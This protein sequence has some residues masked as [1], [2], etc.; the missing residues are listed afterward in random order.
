[1]SAREVPDGGSSTPRLPAGGSST[2]GLPAGGSSTPRLPAGGGVAVAVLALLVGASLLAAA[3]ESESGSGSSLPPSLAVLSPY[4]GRSPRAPAGDE[5]RVLVAL[6]RPALGER[7]DVR[8]LSPG[9]QSAYV[10]SLA[11]EEES[12]RSA[13]EA[14]G[15]ALREV[16]S[17]GRTWNGFAATVDTS[18]LAALSS[19]GVRTQPV[20]RFFPAT[21]E[22]VPVRAALPRPGREPP[23]GQAPVALLDTGVDPGVPALRGRVAAG[24]DALDRDG[25]A[26]PGSDPRAPSRRETT[27]TALAGLLAAAG[28]RVLP[29]RVAG[30]GTESPD[31]LGRTDTLLAGLESAVDPDGDG[32]V[33]DA[34]RVALVGVNAP[35]AGFGDAPEADAVRSAARLGT[36]VVAAAGNEGRATGPYGVI[37]SPGGAP[38]A[39]TAGAAAGQGRPARVE[40]D[41]GEEA[42]TG[43]AVLAGS[44]AGRAPLAGPVTGT[45]P[46]RLLRASLQ[47]RAVVVRAN[48]NPAA[49]AAAAAAAGAR[50]VILAEPRPRRPLPLMAAGRVPAPVV[51]VTGEAAR[52]VLAA[53]PR[54][55]VAFGRVT[56]DQPPA[57][58]TPTGGTTPGGTT[59][60]GTTPGGT[61]PGGTTPGGTTPGGTTPGGAASGGAVSGGAVAGGTTTPARP[62]VFSSEGPALDG[63]PKP[64]VLADG[65]ALAPLPG[66]GAGIVAGTA[67]AAARVAAR[68]SRLARERPESTA[69]ALRADLTGTPAAGTATSAP[70]VPLGPLRLV[71]RGGEVTG[72]RFTLGAFDRGDPLEQGARLEPAG[73]LELVLVRRDGT[74]ARRLTPPGGARDLIPAEYAYTLPNQALD[75]LGPGTH[76]FR[77][78]ARPPRR[79][80]AATKRS[81]SFTR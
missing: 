61:T 34:V 21:S 74:V 70:R 73:R 50:T 55:P 16:V 47:G 64:D 42:I 67:V 20:R 54:T 60:G 58:G 53:T 57:A 56:A 23:D 69:A 13:L 25:F 26:G 59:P 49:Q 27:G 41:V 28:E 71:R 36:L 30:Y 52:A 6:A 43:A 11:R 62:A 78:T 44:P 10:R 8:D 32:A 38:A 46:Q 65:A 4:D 37:G 39:L 17:F 1:V 7:D 68:A 51:G 12:L 29:I 72:V 35:Y 81:P 15:V 48:G 33:T 18:D 45:D 14:R 19:L 80:P 5:Q 75:D 24:A 2:R 40:L 77:A 9:E 63:G 3:F 22:P 66:G 76:A 31:A 79:G